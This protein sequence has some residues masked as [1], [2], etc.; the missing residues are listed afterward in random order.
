MQGKLSQFLLKVLPLLKGF[1]GKN[2]YRK[3]VKAVKVFSRLFF[4]IYGI[5]SSAMDT[6]KPAKSVLIFQGHTAI[7]TQ[8]V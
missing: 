8:V 2:L 4:V 3:S 5:I 7:H 6:L 1:V